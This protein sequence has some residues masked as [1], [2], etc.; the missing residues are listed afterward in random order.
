MPVLAVA[1]IA[2]AFLVYIAGNRSVLVEEGFSAAAAEREEG[3]VEGAALDAGVDEERHG[4]EAHSSYA[5]GAPAPAVD[6]SQT[7]GGTG[8]GPC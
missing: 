6:P 1:V 7:N 3:H 2:F 8:Y 5:K 4:R